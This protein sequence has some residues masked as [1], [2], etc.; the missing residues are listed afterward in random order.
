MVVYAI[1]TYKRYAEVKEKT[2][3]VLNKYKIPK[4]D[5]YVFVANNSEKML[6]QDSL[7]SEYNI[8]VGVIKL[9]KQ[10]NFIS[11]YFKEGEKIVYL[12]DDITEITELGNKR[13]NPIKDL[14]VFV[15][16]AFDECISHKLF[17]WGVYPVDNHYFMKKV[18]TKDLR[19][20]VGAFYGVIN[21]HTRELKLWVEEKED[22]LRTL[23]FFVKD[24]GVIRYNFIGIK[25]KYY[26][27]GGM[28]V[29]RDRV[30]EGFK[31]VKDIH[32]R[33]PK[34]TKIKEPTNTNKHYELKLLL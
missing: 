12:D 33:Y 15:K 1:P 17:L 29:N 7:G 23:Q 31:A 25:T 3:S 16:D 6:Y 14:K 22:Y 20:I 30:A 11:N 27:K 21:R 2:L 34:L 8:I 24:G 9:Y 26:A 28:S 18:I 19:Y 4:E 13:L 10:R 5:I 32:I